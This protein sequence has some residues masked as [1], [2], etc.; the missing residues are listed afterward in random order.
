MIP[1]SFTRPHDQ[2][3]HKAHYKSAKSEPLLVETSPGNI[4]NVSLCIFPSLS[5]V[6]CGQD[7][8]QEARDHR[9]KERGKNMLLVDTALLSSWVR[10][11]K[12]MTNVGVDGGE[13][14]RRA[15]QIG[16]G[17]ERGSGGELG[18]KIKWWYLLF[19]PPFY[20]SRHGNM[21]G[22]HSREASSLTKTTEKR[23]V[24]ESKREQTRHTVCMNE[25]WKNG[26]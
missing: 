25:R 5:L 10:G 17:T 12:R 1:R 20:S 7:P 11:D 13:W 19:H 3:T 15:A 24:S 16:G 26:K 6:L 9:F 14:S 8:Q 23:G 22:G 4:W 18:E 21:P 2:N